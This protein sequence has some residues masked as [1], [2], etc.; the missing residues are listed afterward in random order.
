[1]HVS[2]RAHVGGRP[3]PPFALMQPAVRRYMRMPLRTETD[4]TY[5]LRPRA[6]EW[7]QPKTRAVLSE[8]E[9]CA[10][11]ALNSPTITGAPFALRWRPLRRTSSAI[12]V[13][14]GDTPAEGFNL[15]T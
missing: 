1:M 6:V 4:T 11:A 8:R 14:V 5:A 10:D 7:Q 15:D 2:I 9:C 3:V 13:R 12:P